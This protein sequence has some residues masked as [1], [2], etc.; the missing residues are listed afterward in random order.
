MYVSISLE[1]LGGLVSYF[2]SCEESEAY[3]GKTILANLLFLSYIFVS[4]DRLNR[5]SQTSAE[6]TTGQLYQEM[7]RLHRLCF[8]SEPIV[9]VV[10]TSVSSICIVRHSYWMNI[11]EWD[12]LCSRIRG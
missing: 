2:L 7:T 4:M 3:I 10:I 1:Q 5:L 8:I 12:G 11:W 6:N 9:A